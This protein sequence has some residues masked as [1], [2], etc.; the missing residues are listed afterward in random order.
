MHMSKIKVLLTGMMTSLLLI[1]LPAI[2][3]ADTLKIAVAADSNKETTTISELAA[4]APFFLFFDANG[5]LLKAVENPLK[6]LSG[7][8]G[9]RAAEFL[10]GKGTTLLISEN[11]GNKM[12]QTLA[13]YQI[14]TLEKKGVIHD[15][16]Q[17]YLKKR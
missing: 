17:E 4:R 5:N 6:D 14:E 10:A 9:P 2:L 11:V 12:K 16:V 8:V 1:S 7:G 15:V 13:D 3:S